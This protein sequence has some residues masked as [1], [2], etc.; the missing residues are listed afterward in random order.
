MIFNERYTVLVNK[1]RKDKALNRKFLDKLKKLKPAN[2]DSQCSKLHDEVFQQIDCLQCGNCCAIAGPRLLGK[3]IDR[4][5][6]GMKLRPA[7]FTTTYVRT[8]EDGD[9]V[10]K[11]MPCP[12]LKEDNYCCIYNDRPNACREFP[13]TNQSKMHNKLEITFQNTMICPAVALVVEGLR[14]IYL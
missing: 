9:Y 13:H 11:R 1:A 14:K 10:F 3:D 2:L 5:A 7:E 6:K 8:D 4:M 12:M